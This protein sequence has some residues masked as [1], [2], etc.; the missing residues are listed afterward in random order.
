MYL[1]AAGV[2]E[3]S[4][5]AP[6]PVVCSIVQIRPHQSSFYLTASLDRSGELLKFGA[7]KTRVWLGKHLGLHQSLLLRSQL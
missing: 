7:G 3:F 2:F 5:S 1:K 6:S 4:A